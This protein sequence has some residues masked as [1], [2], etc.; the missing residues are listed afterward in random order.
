MRSMVRSTVVAACVVLWAATALAQST[1]N[2][3]SGATLTFKGFISATAFGQD[4]SFTFGNGQ[5]AEFPVTPQCKVDCW[6]GGGDVRNTRLTL[7]FD[8]PKV[9]GDWKVGGTIEMDFFGGFGSSTNSAFVDQQ[10]VPRLRLGYA[11]ISNGST[12]IQIGQ[13]WS[14][15]FGYTAL[16]LS[17]IAFPLGYGAAGDIGWR[18]PGI[19]ITQKLT[20]KDSSVNADLQVAGMSGS[21]NAPDC[22]TTTNCVNYLTAGN[23]TWPQGEVRFN[24]GG[25][26]GDNST[27]STYIVGHIDSK[28]TSG[29][30]SSKPND[31]L[32]GSAVEIGAKFQIGPFLLQGNGYTGHAIGQQFAA[33][34]QFG[35][36][37]STGGWFQLGFD[38]TK[39][40]GLYGFWGLDDP[41]DSDV[42]G[43][44]NTRVKNQ[45]YAGMLRW[46]A[47]PFALGLEY[48]FDRLTTGVAKTTTIG[49]QLA[50]SALYNF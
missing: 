29:V 8:G 34:T 40:W 32:V 9:V 2:V 18:F 1:V 17:H 5:N 21:W 4:Q 50:L 16:S 49:H 47:G 7:V 24:L 43:S 22:A 23:A 48:L 46:K 30:G 27:W 14:P 44:G 35:K 19:F 45:M 36:I 41:K 38:F 42:I 20:G 6:F 15:L 12:T 11:Q 37:E 28:D 10:P 13:Q 25:K 39:N 33:I 31:R 3:G 26:M